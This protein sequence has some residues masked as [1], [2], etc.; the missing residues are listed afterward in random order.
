MKATTVRDVGG[1]ESL[2]AL[3]GGNYAAAA[4][5]WGAA[6]TILTGAA[7]LAMIKGN[8]CRFR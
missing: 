6:S 4:A 7:N 1:A 5:N 3:A 8:K 2:N